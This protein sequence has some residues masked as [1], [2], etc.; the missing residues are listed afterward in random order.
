MTS[1]QCAK[2]TNLS[3]YLFM[4][5]FLLD[6]DKIVKYSTPSQG[7]WR[8]GNLPGTSLWPTSDAPFDQPVRFIISILYDYMTL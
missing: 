2:I 4:F 8:W 6:D 3:Q 1:F 5:R 7:Y